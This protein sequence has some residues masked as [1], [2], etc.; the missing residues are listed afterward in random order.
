MKPYVAQLA[1][2]GRH[3]AHHSN[4]RRE[5]LH[6]MVLSAAAAA[7][8][9]SFLEAATREGPVTYVLEDG[10]ELEV[11]KAKKG[12]TAVRKSDGKVVARRPTGSFKVKDGGGTFEL[13]NGTVVKAEA[14][15]S[16]RGRGP[17]AGH[18]QHSLKW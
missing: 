3:M 16:M 1:Q 4:S 5:F 17:D 13:K 9:M 18:V 14:S 15:M 10:S 12:Y 8:P 6:T 2:E 11:K 7:T